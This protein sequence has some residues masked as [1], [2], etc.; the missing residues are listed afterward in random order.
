MEF[1]NI[2]KQNITTLKGVTVNANAHFITDTSQGWI[3]S[4][5]KAEEGVCE[6]FINY[7]SALNN[8]KM[9]QEQPLWKDYFN[10]ELQDNDAKEML[11]DHINQ[12]LL[13]VIINVHE[14]YKLIMNEII[15]FVHS[16]L[17][18]NNPEIDE[19]VIDTF[20]YNEIFQLDSNDML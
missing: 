7:I 20:V 19:I 17:K 16:V 12:P 4:N 14:S 11:I 13:H 15:H 18:K 3:F 8:K 5:T 2:S 10:K 1:L 6:V 9:M